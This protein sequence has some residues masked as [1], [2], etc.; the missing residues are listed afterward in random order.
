MSLKTSLRRVLPK[1]LLLSQYPIVSI[2]SAATADNSY[3]PLVLAAHLTRPE[4]IRK[5]LSEI[6]KSEYE[7]VWKDLQERK[8]PGKS[9][10]I[11]FKMT[12]M[13]LRKSDLSRKEPF[14]NISSVGVVYLTFQRDLKRLQENG[15]LFFNCHIDYRLDASK[16]GAK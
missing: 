10:N 3:T 16:A 12:A 4:V 13:L 9:L 6:E 14:Y 5:C 7:F 15:E 8:D 2:A 11:T 1:L